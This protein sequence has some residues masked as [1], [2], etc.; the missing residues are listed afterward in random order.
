MSPT[1]HEGCICLPLSPTYQPDIHVVLQEHTWTLLLKEMQAL[2]SEAQLK[3]QHGSETCWLSNQAAV[4]DLQKSL[5]SLKPVLEQVA[6]TGDAM[7]PGLPIHVMT[8]ALIASL[9]VL[10]D[11]LEV[12][13]NCR[14]AFRQNSFNCLTVKGLLQHHTADLQH[15]RKIH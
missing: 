12:L 2:L 8:L 6:A 15:R 11:I 1:S 14:S 3:L 5:K 9:L 7:A 13:G 10:F 4:D